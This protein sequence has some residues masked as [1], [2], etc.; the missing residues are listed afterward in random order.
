MWLSWFIASEGDVLQVPF[1][2]KN[3][4]ETAFVPVIKQ[5][6]TL[7]GNQPKITNVHCFFV[8]MKF[9]RQ[10]WI[11]EMYYNRANLYAPLLN[12]PK[13]LCKLKF[14]NT[15]VTSKLCMSHRLTHFLD[16]DLLYFYLFI[17]NCTAA[18][19]TTFSSCNLDLEHYV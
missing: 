5:I 9:R 4:S 19:H 18:N 16:M 7:S 13:F 14:V 1:T 12:I 6:T 8:M 2:L 17:F 10:R 3:G 15:S 11:I